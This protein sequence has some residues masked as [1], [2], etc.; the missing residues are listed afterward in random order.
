M[1]LPHGLLSVSQRFR[2]KSELSG[3]AAK[4]RTTP[5]LDKLSYARS[6]LEF[7]KQSWLVLD[8]VQ[9]FLQWGQ[10]ERSSTQI[11]DLSFSSSGGPESPPTGSL[12]PFPRQEN[13]ISRAWGMRLV[14]FD[15][16]GCWRKPACKCW[17]I[18]HICWWIFLDLIV[19][20]PS[21]RGALSGFVWRQH[22]P[23]EISGLSIVWQSLLV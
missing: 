12:V 11:R 23:V 6:L 22:V 9:V 13:E 5:W 16:W 4:G 7:E 20:P 3:K 8:T 18:S 2:M 10:V 14:Y 21:L 15:T 19:L 17:P 1:W